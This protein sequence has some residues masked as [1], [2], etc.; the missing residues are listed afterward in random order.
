MSRKQAASPSIDQLVMETRQAFEFLIGKGYGPPVVELIWPD[1]F[2]GGFVLTY[3]AKALVVEVRYLDT[4][5]VVERDGRD[6]F[7]MNQP[8]SFAGNMFSRQ[9]LLRCI[10]QIA[11]DV[12]AAVE[13]PSS[14]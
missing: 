11:D 1:S 4:E 9:N 5:M 12:A 13:P 3:R 6:L 2:K 10:A 14:P 8:G 7:G